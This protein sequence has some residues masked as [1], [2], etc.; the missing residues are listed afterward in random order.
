MGHHYCNK[1]FKAT[2]FIFR[3]LWEDEQSMQSLV[4]QVFCEEQA[5]HH[6]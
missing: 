1:L 6:G 5:V 2:G 4:A 3:E